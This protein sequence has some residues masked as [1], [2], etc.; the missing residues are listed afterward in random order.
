MNSALLRAEWRAVRRAS[1]R[2]A[3]QSLSLVGLLAIAMVALVVTHPEHAA[4]YARSAGQWF[5]PRAAVP[6]AAQPEVTAPL[7]A[8]LV[9]PGS[10]AGRMLG[11]VSGAAPVNAAEAAPG[12]SPSPV[13][14]TKVNTVERPLTA[15]EKR[16]AA[17][18]L[19]KK[20]HV[21]VDAVAMLVDAAYTTG[22]ELDLDPLLLLS[23]IGVESGFN[24]FAES[25]AGASGLMQL[26]AKVHRD[27]LADFGGANI[28]LNPVVSLRVGA[29]VLKDCIR[30]G[31]SVADGL[32]LYVG[33]GTGAD[34]GYGARVIQEKDRLAQVVRGSVKPRI[35]LIPSTAKAR[36]R[37]PDIDHSFD[38]VDPTN[39][40][41]DA[42]GRVA[43]L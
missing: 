2:L 32:R 14:L 43:A 5:L 6:P 29:V 22:H 30:R 13:Q 19:S 36:V 18:Y 33:A 8:S 7:G 4:E 38:E 27:K 16:E 26:M 17:S 12:E 31:G 34:S 20:Y 41:L 37:Q 10:E 42:S 28:A 35:E 40:K 23:V 9:E 3:Q 21:N 25:N 39:L 24:P 15:R 11:L 1:L